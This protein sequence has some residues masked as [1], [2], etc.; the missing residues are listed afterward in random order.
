MEEGHKCMSL[1]VSFAG[2]NQLVNVGMDWG[3]IGLTWNSVSKTRSDVCSRRAS[4]QDRT[5]ITAWWF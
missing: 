2:H 3:R 5:A 1:G 4:R